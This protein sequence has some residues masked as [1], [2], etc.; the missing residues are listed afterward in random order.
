MNKLLI[1]TSNTK[2]ELNSLR[3]NEI[4]MN[5]LITDIL[6]G[7]TK[8]K[9]E[10]TSYLNNGYDVMNYFAKFEEFLPHSMIIPSF[11]IV[12]SQMPELD[13]G[14]FCPLPHIN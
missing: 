6:A 12:R 2:F 7:T 8:Q 14:F 4:T 9:S 13:Q 11:L 1:L 3:N 10:M 5:L